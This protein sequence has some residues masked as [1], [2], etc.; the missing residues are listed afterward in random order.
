MA[1]SNSS[2]NAFSC[3]KDRC[4][5]SSVTDYAQ[6]VTESL[7]AASGAW[8]GVWSEQSRILRRLDLR[9]AKQRAL[10]INTQTS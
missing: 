2:I 7:E 8:D 6:S 9:R 4:T 5:E 10:Q 1:A 3:S